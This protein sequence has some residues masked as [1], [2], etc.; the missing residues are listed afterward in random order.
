MPQHSGSRKRI[1]QRRDEPHQPLDVLFGPSHGSFQGALLP[2]PCASQCS[3][4]PRM[5]PGRTYAFPGGSLH[6]RAAGSPRVDRGDTPAM[7]RLPAST[8]RR[9]GSPCHTCAPQPPCVTCKV[10]LLRCRGALRPVQ[11]L[12]VRE[13]PGEGPTCGQPRFFPR[14]MGDAEHPPSL[15]RRGSVGPLPAPS[16]GPPG[17]PL[18]CRCHTSPSHR[19]M[20]LPTAAA[21]REKKHVY[22]VQE[23][24]ILM[25]L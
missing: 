24:G 17:V 19:G 3:R 21:A 12:R 23:K 20:P 11:Q 10:P 13:R 7:P 14:R 4:S 25:L 2:S 8:P 9:G 6:Q 15:R 5:L 22:Y 1:T 16:P 18:S